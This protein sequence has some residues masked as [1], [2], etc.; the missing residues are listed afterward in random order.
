MANN[1]LSGLFFAYG[2]DSC[3]LGADENNPTKRRLHSYN[4]SQLTQFPPFNLYCS[5]VNNNTLSNRV[6]HR[7]QILSNQ[8]AIC[9]GEIDT[10][11][12]IFCRCVIL[13][14]STAN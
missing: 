6:G 8:I 14:N 2:D 13:T 3:S 9:R 7:S 1:L 10:N 5:L 11:L 4:I 12:G